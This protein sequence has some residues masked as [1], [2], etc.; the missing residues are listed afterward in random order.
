MTSV[1]PLLLLS[2]TFKD[3]GDDRGST[4]ITQDPLLIVVGWLA[5]LILSATRITL[6]HVTSHSHRSQGLGLNIT[7]LTS[8]LTSVHTF[9]GA[10][11][12]TPSL[13]SPASACAAWLPAFCEQGWNGAAIYNTKTWKRPKYAVNRLMDKEEMVHIYNGILLSHEKEWNWVFCR[14]TDR[15]RICWHR[16]K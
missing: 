13:L 5:T 9:F 8:C 2:S 6:C 16:V 11:Q 1:W 15:P 4:W 3:L 12:F 10:D 14:D 7:L